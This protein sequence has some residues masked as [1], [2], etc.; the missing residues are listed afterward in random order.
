MTYRDGG[1]MTR[2][3]ISL[4]FSEIEPVYEGDYVDDDKNLTDPGY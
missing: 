2:Y 3:S 1:S 4:S